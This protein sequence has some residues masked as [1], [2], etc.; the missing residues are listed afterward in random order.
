MK[1]GLVTLVEPSGDVHVYMPEIHPFGLSPVQYPVA[2]VLYSFQL[3]NKTG[4]YQS[5]KPDQWCWIE[6]EKNDPHKL[7]IIGFV[8]ENQDCPTD[9]LFSV[10]KDGK[11]FTF[12]ETKLGT[13]LECDGDVLLNSSGRYFS[14]Y[15]LL[16]SLIKKVNELESHAVSMIGHT[17]IVTTPGN[18]TGP[19]MM[20]YSPV[21]QVYK[22][23]ALKPLV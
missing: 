13:K 3:E 18:P 10:V 14:L 22:T 17:H 21:E 5:V 2:D 8:V 12:N 9:S 19:S 7:V 20:L 23:A 4:V 11:G 15:E 16:N 6:F 1:R